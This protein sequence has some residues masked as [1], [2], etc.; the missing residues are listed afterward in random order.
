MTRRQGIAISIALVLV[1]SLL[2]WAF[3]PRPLPVEVA[4]VLRAP[5]EQ[6]IDEDGRTRVRQRYVV[7]APLAGR[8]A[9][10]TLDPGDAVAAGA[11]VARIAPTAPALLD[12]RTQRELAERVGAA[13]AQLA[14][15]G[16]EVARAE[17]ALA[18]AQTDLSRQTT[19]QGEGFL[20]PAA[21][22][23]AA[24]GVRVQARALDAAQAARH[25][26]EHAL[27]QARAAAAT[28]RGG[29]ER[30]SLPV[31]SPVTGQVLRVMQQSEGPVALGTPL[32]EV[33]DLTDLEIVV[34]LLSTDAARIGSGARVHVDVAGTRHAGRV[35]RIEPAAFT[36]VSALGVE[37]QRVNVIV[38]LDPPPAGAAP[39]AVG[40][41]FRVDLRIVVLA[42]PEAVVA[43]VAALF[44]AGGSGADWAVF[45]LDGERVVRRAVKVAA[46]GPLNASI[47]TGLEPGDR[48]VVY[49]SD[50][51]T[52]GRRVR[53]V[54]GR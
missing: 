25:A 1:A 13:E 41:G 23:Q 30:G 46:R 35:R 29:H 16:A 6:T 50:A 32:V 17:A 47:A 22:D 44:R 9:R 15:A 38:D 31:T 45:A 11:P 54:R 40:D 14:Q 52:D 20:S 10:I 39:L 34:D 3:R 4:E 48:V 33:A 36:K 28:M 37:E 43:P 24:L 7:A 8:L 12:A 53:V 49:P 19:L 5:F 18:Q 51:L 42:Q 2:V 21:R 27:A 26:A